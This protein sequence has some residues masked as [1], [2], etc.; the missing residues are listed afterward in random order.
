MRKY[1]PLLFLSIF[2]LACVS[3][4]K[5]AA[6]DSKMEEIAGEYSLRAVINYTYNDLS[7]YGYDMINPPIG[8]IEKKGDTWYFDYL[9]PCPA[10]GGTINFVKVE[11]PMTWEPVLDAYCF[12]GTAP[13]GPDLSSAGTPVLFYDTPKKKVA[14]IVYDD[15]DKPK[16]RFVWTKK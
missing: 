10:A 9:L 7:A 13:A 5:E 12:I 11:Q 16:H 1:I 3:C 14:Y 4:S 8:T 2:A 15:K 6:I